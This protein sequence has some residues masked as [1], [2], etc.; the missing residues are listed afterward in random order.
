MS[1]LRVK[2]ET[3]RKALADSLLE[4][5]RL[6]Q[7]AHGQLEVFL[8]DYHRDLISVVEIIWMLM[9]SCASVWNIC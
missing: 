9:P 7:H 2:R 6:V 3:R 1:A 4:F 8:I 5:E